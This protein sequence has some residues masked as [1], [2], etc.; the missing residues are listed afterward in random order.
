MGSRKLTEIGQSAQGILERA[1]WPCA[2]VTWAAFAISRQINPPDFEF[3]VLQQG[4]ARIGAVVGV[5][6]E[7]RFKDEVWRW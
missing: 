2:R 4:R 1:R 6:V 3:C 5:V 7:S